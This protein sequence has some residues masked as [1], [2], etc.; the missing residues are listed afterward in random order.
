MTI[1]LRMASP[2]LVTTC[3]V[4]NTPYQATV[5]TGAG[6]V[7]AR[8]TVTKMY[9]KSSTKYV[10]IAANGEELEVLGTTQLSINVFG[11]EFSTECIIVSNLDC[12]LIL[13]TSFLDEF[14]FDIQYRS[15]AISFES[16]GITKNIPIP[17]ERHGNPGPAVRVTK[18]GHILEV[19]KDCIIPALTAYKIINIDE[20]NKSNGTCP[21]IDFQK[22]RD[23]PKNMK[24]AQITPHNL[25][26]CQS[27]L[28]N[29]G[30][31][32][33]YL[34]AGLALGYVTAL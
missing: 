34:K 11:T 27:A 6:K 16:N 15:H 22:G 21:E 10:V 33:L 28:A 9:D 8:H 19:A 17:C 13:G 23:W 4:G 31:T 30:K 1:D 3:Y 18:K 2:I 5:D 26:F 14:G 25:N 32:S 24:I 12:D 20:K 7:L 29:E